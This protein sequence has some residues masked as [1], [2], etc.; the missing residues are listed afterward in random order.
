MKVIRIGRDSSN[1]VV[2]NDPLVSRTHCHIIQDDN[3]RFRLI[4]TNSSNGTFINGLQR[5]G[6]VNLN[7]T[8]IVIIGNTT[9]PWQTYFNNNSGATISGPASSIPVGGYNYSKPPVRPDNFLVWSILA[10]IFCCL[11]FGI[12]AI[13]NSSRVDRLWSDGDYEGAKEAARKA[14]TW[15]WWSFALGIFFDL[16]Y[17]IYYIIVGV[18]IGLAGW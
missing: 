16:F 12:P 7:Q 18:A 5:H 3:G 15:F 11:P 6:E 10:T 17:L 13:V 4:D 14:R 9:L 8:D 2:I 1:D